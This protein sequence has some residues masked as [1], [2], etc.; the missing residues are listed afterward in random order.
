M[1]VTAHNIPLIFAGVGLQL[2]ATI[3]SAVCPQLGDAQA[4]DDNKHLVSV[5]DHEDLIVELQ[6]DTICAQ[7]FLQC[8]RLLPMMIPSIWY[9]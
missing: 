7:L 1:R 8:L 5:P 6:V 2:S 4:R 9:S 3:R